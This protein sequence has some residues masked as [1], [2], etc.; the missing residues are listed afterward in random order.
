MYKLGHWDAL[1]K[2]GLNWAR[3]KELLTGSR[4]QDL[5]HQA[6]VLFG[7]GGPGMP[8]M[9]L[10]ALRAATPRTSI[11]AQ[12]R[13]IGMMGAEQN[14][15]RNARLGVGGAAGTLAAG[16]AYAALRNPGE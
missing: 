16:G 9:T 12:Q 7:K 3:G 2:L 10:E 4:V 1:V 13:L 15:V 8:P 6:Q 11:P 14:A 5:G